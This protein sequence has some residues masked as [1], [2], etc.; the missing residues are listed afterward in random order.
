[1][2]FEYINSTG[3]IHGRKITYKTIDDGFDPSK[4]LANTKKLIEEEKVFL[5]Y[6]NTG[7]AQTA[8]ISPLIT[9]SK[10]LYLVRLLARRYLGINL[11]HMYL[12]CDLAMPMKQQQLLSNS[13]KLA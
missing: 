12:T 1:M 8:A 10:I 4:A 9:E 5:I 11:V 3:G 6:H 13:Y 7:T 2:Y